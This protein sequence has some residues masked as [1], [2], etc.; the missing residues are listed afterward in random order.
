MS[1]NSFRSLFGAFP[2]AVSIV[3]TMDPTGMPYGFT[4]NSLSAVSLDP[5][6]LSICV[7][8]RSRTLRAIRS[9]R[10]FAVNVLADGGQRAA[11]LFAGRSDRR[12]DEVR[13]SPSAVAGGA[14][15]LEDITLAYAECHV[16]RTFKAGDH[17]L[18]IGRVRAVD[19]TSRS[20]L[21]YQKGLYTAWEPPIAVPSGV[22]GRQPTVELD[23]L[24][25]G[26]LHVGHLQWGFG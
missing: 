2:T 9:S 11:Q 4:C 12:F 14:P 18:L 19:V 23:H 26:D 3:T 22:T 8:N 10:S 17:W 6:L 16:A 15:L 13:W 25:E 1:A 24:A 7:D 5:P 20:P 21:L